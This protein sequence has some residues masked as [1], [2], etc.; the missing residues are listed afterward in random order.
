MNHDSV[1]A[2]VSLPA[3]TKLRTTSRRLLSSLKML[4]SPSPSSMNLDSRSCFIC[5]RSKNRVLRW[6]P[7]QSRSARLSLHAKKPF[8]PPKGIDESV[9]DDDISLIESLSKCVLGEV[10]C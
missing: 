4:P 6:Q 3:I 2:V 10:R 1:A 5:C 7:D 8:D 9:S